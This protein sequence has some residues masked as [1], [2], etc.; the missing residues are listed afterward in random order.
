MTA[1]GQLS[2]LPVTNAL[3]WT[4]VHFCWQ[5]LTIC[6]LLACVLSFLPAQASKL[7]YAAGCVAMTFMFL[8]PLITFGLMMA[9]QRSAERQPVIAI[10]G[11]YP[12][13]AA[14]VS[15]VHSAES[16]VSECEGVLDRNLPAV[17]GFWMVGVVL[18]LLRLNLGLMAVGAWKST[19]VE[20]VSSEL[21]ETLRM[22]RVRLGIERAVKLLNSARVCSPIVIG[23]MRPAI[24][25]PL[26]CM[27]GFSQ[28][29]IEAILAHELAHIRRH[30]FLVNLLQSIVE[31]L[32]FYH[33]AVWWVSSQMRRERE[34][35]CDDLAVEITG[36]RL[37]YANALTHLEQRRGAL[38]P[39]G[40]FAATGG[41]L[42]RRIERLL[43]INQA[44]VF[45][46]SMA[47]ILFATVTAAAGLIAHGSARTQSAPGQGSLSS[48]VPASHEMR[49]T[50]YRW[51]NQ[52]VRW[53]ITPEE[54]EAFLRLTDN[55][56]RDMFIQQFWERRSPSTDK[57]TNPFR[58][59]HYQRIA[60]AND[61]FAEGGDPGSETGRGHV[62]IVF[63]K[64]DS[65]RSYPSGD[66]ESAKS[67]EI[68]HYRLIRI[69]EP[70]SKSLTG[71]EFTM[72]SSDINDFDF[73]FIDD[74][75]CGKYRLH[76]AWPGGTIMQNSKPA[77][78]G[79]S[80]QSF[81]SA[82]AASDKMHYG[83]PDLACTFYGRRSVGVEGT[84][85]TRRGYE[86]TYYCVNNSEKKL[87]EEQIGCEWKI[88]RAK[89]LK[90][91]VPEIRGQ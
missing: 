91:I 2:A 31:T 26:G 15:T 43:G 24:L 28:T 85:E 77:D 88:D 64:P 79:R 49:A 10:Q 68:W 44:P 62:Y 53:I 41:M 56:E 45:P 54:R 76:S 34:H 47:I 38:V 72:Q 66:K 1:I 78:H 86:N 6:I 50:Y 70:S 12:G 8:V 69:Q 30:D 21:K 22:L 20:P 7:R 75:A 33:P 13:F 73:R 80:Q 59:E 90:Y 4:L 52:E 57:G 17:D 5:G 71:S 58:Q 87:F 37:A 46:R 32:F 14:N 39:N 65:I 55:R 74:C 16:W 48:S 61:H 83:R 63:G 84:C 18:L 27:S 23:W 51:L 3:G 29:Q 40:A 11:Q 36:D 82:V 81:I 9:N 60:F 35:C 25:L 89:S 19:E 42:K 67:V